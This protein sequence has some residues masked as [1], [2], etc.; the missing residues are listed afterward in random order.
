M[1]LG[2]LIKTAQMCWKIRNYASAIAI[3][4]GLNSLLVK[5][6]P[7]WKRLHASSAAIMEDL[8]SMQVAKI[9][10]TFSDC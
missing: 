9:K 10:H 6:L 2:K 4:I 1:V 8:E 3:V 7:A 5:Q